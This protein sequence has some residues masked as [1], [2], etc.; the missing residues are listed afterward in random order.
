[1]VIEPSSPGSIYAGLGSGA[2]WKSID[3]GRTWIEMI[4]GLVT[5]YG[6]AIDPARPT[7][8][9]AATNGFGVLSSRDSGETWQ[10]V[11]AGL[12]SLVLRSIAIDPVGGV[13]LFTGTYETG[14]F[15]VW[16]G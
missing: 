6:L 9:Y 11:N 2:V 12:Y 14:A 10:P 16:F 8:L 4:S 13:T 5:V 7:T 15:Q 3:G 1:M